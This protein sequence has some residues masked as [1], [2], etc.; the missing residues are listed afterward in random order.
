M[1]PR[2]LVISSANIDFVQNVTRLPKVGETVVETR[3]YG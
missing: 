1:K 2:I 3:T